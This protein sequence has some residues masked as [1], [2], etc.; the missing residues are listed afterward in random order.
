MTEMI[1]AAVS[2]IER[3]SGTAT[4]DS[5]AERASSGYELHAAAE[6]VLRQK[7]GDQ[8]GIG[9]GGRFA[10]APVTGGP[11]NAP[12]DSGP[13]LS[14]PATSTLAT[15]PPPAPMVAGRSSAAGS[16][17]RRGRPTARWPGFTP[18]ISAASKLVPP[19]SMA[20]TSDQ[21]LR[22]AVNAAPL[23]PLAHPETSV[24]KA[25]FLACSPP[26]T[27]PSLEVMKSCPPNPASSRP[28]PSRSKYRRIR[29]RR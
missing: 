18:R 29:G 15:E 27:P 11:W 14:P 28:S 17:G 3:P 10:P 20:S 9:E 26:I 7:T 22:S 6:Q 4:S 13:T 25:R 5:I 23:T 21:P 16:A 2:S 19:I 12:A 8:G 24:R 1:P